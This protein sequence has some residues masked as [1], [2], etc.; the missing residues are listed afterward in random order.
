[1]TPSLKKQIVVFLAMCA[2]IKK[3][4]KGAVQHKEL[5]TRPDLQKL[6]MFFNL[7]TAEGLQDKV[8]WI[9]CCI[10]VTGSKRTISDFSTD[11]IGTCICVGVIQPKITGMIISLIKVGEYMN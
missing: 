8:L 6:C 1:M 10:F 4:G 2:K 11:T 7:K 5:L 9:T 3:E